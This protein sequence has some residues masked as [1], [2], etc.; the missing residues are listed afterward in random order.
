MKF[1]PYSKIQSNNLKILLYVARALAIIGFVSLIVALASFVLSPF[2]GSESAVVDMGDG[3]RASIRGN[4]Q[5]GVMLI[6]G[7]WSF[8]SALFTLAFSGLCAAAVSAEY[9][10]TKAK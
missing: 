1:Y 5:T 2:F 7:V 3:V 9:Q 10:Y 8:L 4:A 6:T